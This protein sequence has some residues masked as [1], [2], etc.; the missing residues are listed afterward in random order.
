MQPHAILRAR[1]TD[2]HGAADRRKRHGSIGKV[3]GDRRN[4]AAL[5]DP[6]TG[7]CRQLLVGPAAQ[8]GPPTARRD[9]VVHEAHGGGPIM[10]LV[11]YVPCRDV[12]DGQPGPYAGLTESAP[13]LIGPVHRRPRRIAPSWR[14]PV[15]LT[16]GVLQVG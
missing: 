8:V 14:R 3:E 4:A 10:A 13:G 7:R 9:Q 12:A 11:S 6:G 1:R 5:P 15:A 16:E 2:D